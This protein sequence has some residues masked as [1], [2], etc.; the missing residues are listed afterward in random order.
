MSP[1]DQHIGD[2]SGFLTPCWM[3]RRALRQLRMRPSS[4]RRRSL[5]VRGGRACCLLAAAIL[6]ALAPNMAPTATPATAATPTPSPTAKTVEATDDWVC[7]G[8]LIAVQPGLGLVPRH[9][10]KEMNLR[11]LRYSAL[12]SVWSR[13]DI[14]CSR[15][16]SATKSPLPCLASETPG[17]SPCKETSHLPWSPWIPRYIQ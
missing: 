1:R 5:A 4:S 13:D 9:A 10:L 7:D 2:P 15:R 14:A 16:E 12:G 3:M 11:V 17:F 8:E 6:R